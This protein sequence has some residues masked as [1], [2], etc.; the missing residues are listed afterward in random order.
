MAM[1]FVYVTA[2]N[3]EDA[4]RIGRTVVEERWAAC[5]NVLGPLTSV[6]WWE[7]KLQEDSEAALV[8]KT[9]GDLVDGLT[10]R[11]KELHSYSCPCI[12]ALAINGGNGAFL[13]WIGVE[14]RPHL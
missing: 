4:L 11:I 12:V 3:R 8:L 2:P 10:G 9:R 1:A 13:D 7:G 14:T 6:Y 5:A